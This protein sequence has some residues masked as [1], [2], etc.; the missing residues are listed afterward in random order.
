MKAQALVTLANRLADELAA[1]FG[2]DTALILNGEVQHQL[3]R[4]KMKQPREGQKL[5][6]GNAA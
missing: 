2:V 1:R 5:A 3:Y 6:K 4:R